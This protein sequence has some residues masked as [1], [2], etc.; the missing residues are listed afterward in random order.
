MLLNSHPGRAELSVV[1]GI[2]GNSNALCECFTFFALAILS[3]CR[4][5][6]FGG[7]LEAD[8]T[9]SLTLMNLGLLFSTLPRATF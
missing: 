6:I 5:G 9:V 7:I 1:F 3:V 2:F 8:A 4:V